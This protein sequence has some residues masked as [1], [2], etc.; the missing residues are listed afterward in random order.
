[1][2][3]NEKDQNSVVL[4]AELKLENDFQP[5][6]YS[7]W[8][9]QVIK[10]L[11]GADFNSTLKTAT[12]EGIELQPIFVD[13]S[14]KNLP[15][16][17]ELPGFNN[18]LRGTKSAGYLTGGW[19]I[20]QTIYTDSPDKY[21]SLL[22]SGLN[23]GQTTVTLDEAEN[24]FFGSQTK[25]VDNFLQDI[26]LK[27]YSINIYCGCSA[28][29]FLPEFESFLRRHN[30]IF[31]NL[32]G[33][34]YSSP[35]ASL[36]K[37]GYLP[38]NVER[39]FNELNTLTNSLHKKNT[40]LRSILVDGTIYNNAGSSA[41]QDLAF[42]L[43]SGSEY[44]YQLS[45]PGT[46]VNQIASKISFKFGIG[47]FY[48]M[49]IAKLRAVRIL[50][51]K[52]L[53]EYGVD[54]EYRKM[55]IIAQTTMY[56]QTTRDIHNNILRGTTEAFSAILGGIDVLDVTPFDKHIAEANEFSLH[57]ARNIQNILKEETHLDKIIDTAGGSYYVENLTAELCEKAWALFQDVEEQGGIIP[58]LKSS[59]IQDK[60]AEV[61][62]MRMSDFTEGKSILVG[63]NK[64]INSKEEL[65]STEIE[66]KENSDKNNFNEIKKT[67]EITPI[68][69]VRAAEQFEN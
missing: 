9:K 58:A 30:F 10:D 39:E 52:I 3:V 46:S 28:K 54:K 57:L 64:H 25:S 11:K 44:I 60:I 5:T 32:K 15:F 62:K 47:S 23:N 18:Y 24:N 43:A 4:D 33:G 68:T 50:W 34:I 20:S 21:N 1:M 27:K 22:K 14:L 35:I 69:K 6:L 26:D 59:F 13:E 51:S 7:D 19:Q 37:N 36:I 53:E 2:N 8:K 16:V 38:D 48:F 63:V 61:N 42:S 55:H 49:E 29:D 40:E 45:N 56:N 66:L 17:K 65:K 67:F 31:S 12:Y 41:V